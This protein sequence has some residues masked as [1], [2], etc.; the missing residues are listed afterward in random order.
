MDGGEREVGVEAEGC[1]S[2]EAGEAAGGGG[3]G[4]SAVTAAQDSSTGV[5]TGGCDGGGVNEESAVVT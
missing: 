1:V 3:E 5:R 2:D 4:G